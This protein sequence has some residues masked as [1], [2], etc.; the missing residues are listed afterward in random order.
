MLKLFTMM[1]MLITVGG[2]WM[3][4]ALIFC[5]A[6]ARAARKPVPAFSNDREMFEMHQPLVA[7]PSFA[8]ADRQHSSPAISVLHPLRHAA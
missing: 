6:L 8:T 5:L 2:V 7:E 4:V 1:T 3:L